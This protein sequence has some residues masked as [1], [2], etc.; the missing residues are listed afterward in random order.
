MLPS[1]NSHRR[2]T[3]TNLFSGSI[4]SELGMLTALTNIHFGL[5]FNRLTGTIPSEFAN[6]VVLQNL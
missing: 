5:G 3:H 4:P 6:L 1:D 2:H